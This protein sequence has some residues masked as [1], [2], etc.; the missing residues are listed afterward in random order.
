ME[1]MAKKKQ[2]TWHRYT[3]LALVI[4]GLAF[5]VAIL[6]L[7]TRLMLGIGMF[8]GATVKT[9]NNGIFISLGLTVLFL[10][11]Y[12]ILEPEKTRQAFTGRQARH[13]S[14]IFITA[15]AFL[16]ILIV[17][18]WFVFKNP[19]KKDVT[20]DQ[21]NTLAPE[22]MQALES[23]PQPVTAIAFYSSLSTES[24]E[25]LL[26][27]FKS[28]SNG[29]FDYRF[30]NPDTD[31][32]A[33]QEAG[34]TGD[35]K[36]LLKMGENQEIAN[37]ASETE[38]TKALI[39][40]INPEPRA[41]YFLIGHGE[42]SL[43]AGDTSYAIAKQTLES[44]NYTVTSLNLLAENKI[45]EDALAVIIPGPQKQVSENEVELLKKYVDA[46]GSLIVMEDPVITTEFG[47][48]P[49]PLA[50]YLTEDW[51]IT[52]N[53]DIIIDL[54]S[55]E[56]LYAVSV[57]AGQHPITTNLTSNY[58]VILPQARSITISSAMD[59]V[60]QSGLLFTS[61]N[62]WGEVNFTNAEGTQISFDP[63]D[64]PGPLTM[65]AAGENSNSQGRVVVFGDS[66]FA[67]D[68][69]FNAYGN[70]N[71]FV[72]SVDWA[73]EQEDLINITPNTPT[74]RTFIPPT[75]IQLLVIMLGTILCIPGLVVMAGV[76]TW[77]ARRR[78]G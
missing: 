49:D 72:N 23:L 46:G 42:A 1:I 48:S 11:L 25:D 35:G 13:G 76:F 20:Q 58:I 56:P 30:V 55:Q 27:R 62:S 8:S 37:F 6:F 74:T 78:Q 43:E 68:Q 41:V 45:P 32:A 71:I 33:A 63:E 7:I 67:T 54:S 4:A 9:L 14:N 66:D 17:L 51:G 64:L 18:N 3:F 31:P 15:I 75:Q 60:I 39:K 36:I 5:L 40:L 73:A 65:A 53:N 50:D 44:K 21:T 70:G 57:S 69:N 77:L 38:L 28:S 59:G 24:A 10:G 34:I 22:T 19:I 12:A 61:Q 2:A 47:D 16:G 52:L 29:N 26:V